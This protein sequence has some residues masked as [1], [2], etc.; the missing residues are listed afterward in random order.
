MEKYKLNPASLRGQ[1]SKLSFVGIIIFAFLIIFPFQALS[2]ASTTISLNDYIAYFYNKESS[3]LDE[4]YQT[5][6]RTW[7]FDIPY[8]E[9]NKR[10][11]K[12]NMRPRYQMS[13][14]AF[15]AYRMQDGSRARVLV[16]NAVLDTTIRYEKQ[17]AFETFEGAIAAFLTVRLLEREE[18]LP[19]HKQLFNS[20]ERKKILGILSKRLF[21]GLPTKDTENRAAL[22]GAYW[23]Y[24]G[25]YL[26][27]HG[28]INY[29]EFQKVKERTKAKIDQSI[30][31]T[32]ARPDNKYREKG[33]FSLHYHIVEAF[34]LLLYGHLTDKPAYIEK[35]SA[36]TDVINSLAKEDG[37]L[38]AH[39]GHRP[40]GIGAQGYLMAG[41]L[42][43]YFKNKTR[44]EQFFNYA[45]GARFFNDPR[46]PNRLVWYDTKSSS[47][48]FNDDISFVNMAE[49]TLILF[50]ENAP[51]EIAAL[52]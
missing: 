3:F 9:P 15:Y 20:D 45:Y 50:P 6:L 48:I 8:Y 39:I 14:A 43:L 32:L 24:A 46:Y 4:T 1:N 35:A 52:P 18:T 25:A 2:T 13:S 11:M 31:E 30:K 38:D 44:A 40:S 29:S 34:M 27:K 28:I 5:T 49:S 37:F 26:Q 7:H 22:A 33:L 16:R 41:T 21:L 10:W 23:Y 42:N 51:T 19:K 17:P 12:T 47:P 36:M